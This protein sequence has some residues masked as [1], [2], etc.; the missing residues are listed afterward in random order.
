VATSIRER[1]AESNPAAAPERDFCPNGHDPPEASDDTIRRMQTH[2]TRP[3]A[4]PASL[5]GPAGPRSSGLTPASRDGAPDPAHVTPASLERVQASAGNR[6][7]A[8]LVAQRAPSASLTVQRAIGTEQAEAIA[9]QLEDAMSGW[10]TDEEAIYGALSGRTGGDIKAIKAAYQRLFDE[11]L[12]EELRDELTDDELEK[13]SQMMPPTADESTM[14]APQQAA[15]AADRATVIAAQLRDAIEGAGTEEDQIYNSLT[16][17][18]NKELDEIQKAYLSLTGRDLILDLRSDLTRSEL[19]KALNLLQVASAGTFENEFEQKMTEGKSTFG[20]GI[21]DY[22]LHHDRLDI[23]VPVKFVPQA[24]VTPPYALWNSQIDKVWNKF[25][26]IEPSGKHKIPIHLAFKDDPGAER[27]IE[28]HKNS[29]D[30]S[31]DRANA[32]KYFVNMKPTTVPHEFGH[33]LGLQDEYQRFHDDF[34]ALTGYTKTG[35]ENKSGMT[36]AEIASDLF[37][38]LHLDDETKRAPAATKLLDKVGLLVKGR[39]QQGDFALAVMTAYDAAYGKAK[40]LVESMRDYLPK[41]QKWTIQTVFSYASRTVM[42]DPGGLGGSE[43][44]DHA[45]E[46]RHLSSM[47][48]IAKDAWPAFDWRTGPQ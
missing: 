35:P 48:R 3:K 22:A 40:N 19:R 20:H 47:V 1:A 28:V 33:L 44:H 5:A 2:A 7:A 10:G 32:G 15:A 12:D 11:D 25:A 18:S 24:G 38:A 17:R 31:D 46:P 27:E 45:V 9:R 43:T 13:V 21:F 41:K 6:A 34:K 30:P 36:E 37:D 16:G 4:R 23:S 8:E 29:K 39:P 26:L 42:G 14:S